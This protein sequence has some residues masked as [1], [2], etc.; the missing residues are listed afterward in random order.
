MFGGGDLGRER[1]VDPGTGTGTA[2][3]RGPRNPDH[4]CLGREAYLPWSVRSSTEKACIAEGE[5]SA[6]SA[7]EPVSAA[8]GSRCNVHN[9]S[10]R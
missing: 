5:H 3:T 7:Q 8:I 2:Q 10:S 9:G 1:Q 4:V 6:V